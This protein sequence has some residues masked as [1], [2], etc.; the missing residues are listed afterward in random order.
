M[1]P[2]SGET[3][4]VTATVSNDG[5]VPGSETIHLEGPASTT[6]NR[7]VTLDSGE[8]TTVTFTGE[9]ANLTR[10]N[11]TL[12]LSIANDTATTPFRVRDSQ[13]EV[14]KIRG[15]E[16]VTIDEELQFTATVQNTGDAPD[17]QTIEYR[18]DLDGDDEPESYGLNRTVTLAPGNQ[19]TVQFTVPYGHADDPIR[20][21]ELYGT[22]IYGVYSD[23][24]KE[25]GVVVVEGYSSVSTVDDTTSTS[26]A[27]ETVSL[28]E[29]SQEKYGYDYEEISG[30]TRG[31]IEEIHERQPFADGLVLIEVLT[32]EEI[33][34]QQFGLD[35]ETGD[36]FEFTALPVE[37]QQEIE[38]VFDAQFQS[39]TGDKVESWDELSEQHHGTDYENNTDSEQQTIRD[40]YWEQFEDES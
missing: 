39:D 29:I 23:D 26:D 32:R 27:P 16:M 11:H 28:S 36:S 10:G 24:S 17:D 37:T 4:T 12:Q 31:Q 20:R 22:H 19:T 33:A 15:P 21:A 6:H 14:V 3:F 9:T 38:A 34:R 1:R 18:I 30:E 35:V 2:Q 13:F 5:D 8:S 7:S 25:T 40:L